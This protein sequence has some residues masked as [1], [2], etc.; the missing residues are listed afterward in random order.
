MSI[1]QDEEMHLANIDKLITEAE[2]KIDR[3]LDLIERLKSSGA[4]M[5]HAGM[6]FTILVDALDELA[7]QRLAIWKALE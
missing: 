6:V 1:E 4:D 5:E 7:Q 2:E 3:Q